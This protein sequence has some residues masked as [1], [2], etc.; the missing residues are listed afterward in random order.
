[1]SESD[2]SIDE[3]RFVVELSVFRRRYAQFVIPIIGVLASSGG[4]GDAQELSPKGVRTL[5]PAGAIK[6]SGTWSL[7]TRAGD[8]IYIAGMRGIDP[9]TDT[10]CP[11]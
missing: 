9:S 8:F 6:P 4:I 10:P 2:F 1:M 5:A 11:R 7:G 3:Q